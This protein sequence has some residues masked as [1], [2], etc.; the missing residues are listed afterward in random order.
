MRWS[1]KPYLIWNL[2]SL[3]SHRPPIP[4][5]L[6]SNHMTS[7]GLYTNHLHPLP[8][9]FCN[10]KAGWTSSFSSFRFQLICHL[11]ESLSLTTHL[12]KTA[13]H[14][15]IL[16]HGTYCSLKWSYLWC[17]SCLPLLGRI[18]SSWEQG[19]FSARGPECLE[20]SI[21]HIGAQY[22]FGRRNSDK[23]TFI[24]THMTQC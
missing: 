24:V 17:L 19:P 4:W 21:A 8:G 23:R 13:P 18:S 12:T 10:E 9:P 16:F 14:P 22:I 7:H 6:C 20:W 2:L 11:Q 3:C 15:L 1:S 5:L